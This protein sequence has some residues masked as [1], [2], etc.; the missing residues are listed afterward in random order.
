MIPN[1]KYTLD[2]VFTPTNIKRMLAIND[3]NFI[4]DETETINYTRIL[5]PQ[6]DAY[7]SGDVSKSLKD[8]F[9]IESLFDE[10]KCDFSNLLNDN[11]Y[12]DNFIHKARL[13]VD[14]G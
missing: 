6:F 12:C 8:Y 5:F 9:G 1:S 3:Y 10:K 11:A 7:Y 13:R 2:R 4:D 14:P